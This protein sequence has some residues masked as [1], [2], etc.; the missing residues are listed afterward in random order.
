MA[1]DENFYAGADYGLDPN[2]KN[3]FSIGAHPNYRTSAASLALTTDARTANQLSEVFKKFPGRTSMPST[4][5]CSVIC[6]ESSGKWSQHTF[7]IIK[8]S[9]YRGMK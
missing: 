9:G 1:G 4:S 8:L 3:E 2:F 5:N 7:R 6:A